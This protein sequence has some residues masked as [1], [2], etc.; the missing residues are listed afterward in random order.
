MTDN[1]RAVL[2]RVVQSLFLVLIL[3]FVYVLIR[4]LGTT[5][6][7]SS[8]E[9]TTILNKLSKGATSRYRVKGERIWISRFS[10]TQLNQLE[11][12]TLFVDNQGPKCGSLEY[13]AFKIATSL[14]GAELVYT[15]NPPMQL[16]ASANWI[17]GYVN[18]ENGAVYDLRGRAY[19]NEYLML[20]NNQNS[21]ASNLVPFIID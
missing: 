1:R 5:A 14:G 12:L 6:P 16:S 19:L 15:E 17:G 2:T 10:D 7:N 11:G 3:A 8:D 4:G 13:C 21:Q 18:P 9:S 20:S